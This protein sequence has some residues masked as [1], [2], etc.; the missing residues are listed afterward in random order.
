[1]KDKKRL[2]QIA[3]RVQEAGTHYRIQENGQITCAWL[4]FDSISMLYQDR[5]VTKRDIAFDITCPETD[6]GPADE[7]P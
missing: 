4:V 6:R 5:S 7:D 3:G 2:V 1:M